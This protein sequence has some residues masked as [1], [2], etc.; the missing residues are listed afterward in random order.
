MQFIIL[1]VH[2][3]QI[4]SHFRFAPCEYYWNESERKV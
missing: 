4:C 2:L 3:V 1:T